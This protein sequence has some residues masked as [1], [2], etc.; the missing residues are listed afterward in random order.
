MNKTLL[1]V[2][3]TIVQSQSDGTLLSTNPILSDSIEDN[4]NGIYLEGKLGPSC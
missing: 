1:L 2:L 4:E 3:V